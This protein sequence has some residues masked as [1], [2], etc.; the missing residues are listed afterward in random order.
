MLCKCCGS[1]KVSQLRY[2]QSF[3]VMIFE[4][5]EC[6]QRQTDHIPD[7]TLLKYY[8]FFYRGKMTPDMIDFWVRKYKEAGQNQIKIVNNF[9]PSRKLR[10]LDYGGATGETADMLRGYFSHV[11]VSEYDENYLP[12]LHSKKYECLSDTELLIADKYDF[13]M[14]SHVFEHFSNPYKLLNLFANITRPESIIY[15]EVPNEWRL[16]QYGLVGNGHLWFF[17]KKMIMNFISKDPRFDI[18]DIGTYGDEVIANLKKELPTFKNV[19]DAEKFASDLSEE[20]NV[21]VILRRN[22][23]EYGAYLYDEPYD[24]MLGRYSQYSMELIQRLNNALRLLS[25]YEKNKVS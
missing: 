15:I 12:I 25:M 10:A 16:A 3:G 24:L 2:N 9:F 19:V 1:E 18:V 14:C 13:I 8:K 6:F 22:T 11:T 21:Y 23:A 5:L 17:S 7:E 4:C 20:V